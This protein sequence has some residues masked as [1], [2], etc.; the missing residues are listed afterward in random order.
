M[1][2]ESNQP[3]PSDPTASSDTQASWVIDTT[4][5]GNLEKDVPREEREA[6]ER[7]EHRKTLVKPYIDAFLPSKPLDF[8]LAQEARWE[9]K[10]VEDLTEEEQS[11]ARAGFRNDQLNKESIVSTIAKKEIPETLLPKYIE[12]VQNIVQLLTPEGKEPDFYT[13]MFSM[14]ISDSTEDAHLY[15]N[16]AEE[17]ESKF[18]KGIDVEEFKKRAWAFREIVVNIT[19]SNRIPKPEAKSP[20]EIKRLFAA[21]VDVTE[22]VSSLPREQQESKAI[23]LLFGVAKVIGPHWNDPEQ[24][25]L[26]K[27]IIEKI[28]GHES[29]EVLSLFADIISRYASNH[30]LSKDA[31]EGLSDRLLPALQQRDPQVEVLLNGGNIWGMGKGEFGAGDFLTHSYAQKVTPSNINE[32]LLILREIPTSQLAKLEQNRK[33]G[34]TLSGPFGI[35]RDFIHDQRPH[36]HELVS[37]MVHF[38]DTGDKSKIE[39]ILPKTD[40]FNTQERHD[41]FFE[42]ENYE[43]EVRE[44]DR[45]GAFDEDKVVKPIDIL[46]RVSENT[47]PVPDTPPVTSDDEL[48]KKMEILASTTQRTT[49]QREALKSVCDYMNGSLLSLMRS[50]QIGIN[51]DTIEALSWVEQKAFRIMQGLTFE[52]QVGAYKDD[53]FVSLLKFQELIASPS[54]FDEEKFDD[55]IDEIKS[56]PTTHSTEAYQKLSKRVLSNIAGLADKYKKQGRKDTGALWSGNLAHELIGLVDYRPATT[57]IGKRFRQEALKRITQPGHH[58]GD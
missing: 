12:S 1:P 28:Q 4:P 8:Y 24:T 38:Y 18:L 26:V 52:D 56:I 13:W 46:R 58:P 16:L 27:H 54:N 21:D 42:R 40:Y 20:E 37:A 43:N 5:V 35:L 32:L 11:E 25:H 53:W 44:I 14:N 51:P 47:K 49:A 9:N 15:N 50:H 57:E 33:D 22:F 29:S 23:R 45:W 41:M 34:L 2:E 39:A 3:L 55:F 48:N 17:W 10:E 7:L 19:G 30:P 6:T 31:V 36:V